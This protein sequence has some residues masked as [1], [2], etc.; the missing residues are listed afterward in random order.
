MIAR[1]Y[2][3]SCGNADEIPNGTVTCAV[4]KNAI[5][6]IADTVID[7]RVYRVS[8]SPRE[9]R[10][11]ARARSAYTGIR[12]HLSRPSTRVP[13]VRANVTI[14]FP[15]RHVQAARIARVNHPR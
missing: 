13:F 6:V 8:A 12:A 3:C 11:R 14:S 4:I 9:L 1:M 15:R 5:A 2:A 10:A 7:T